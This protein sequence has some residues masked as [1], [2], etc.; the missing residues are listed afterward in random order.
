MRNLFI[1]AL[2]A[3][4]ATASAFTPIPAEINSVILSNFNTEFKTASEVTWSVTK[5]YSKAVFTKD[6]AKMEVYYNLDGVIIGTSRSISLNE[7]PIR[8]KRS[9]TKLFEGYNVKEAI[10]FEGFEE[11]GYYISGENEKE[12]VILKVNESNHVSIFSRTKK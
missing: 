5:D 9:F 4:S 11:V 8:A 12:T 7:L 3:I 6:N 10:C 2:L 1:A